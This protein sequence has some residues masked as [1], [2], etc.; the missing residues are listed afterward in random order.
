MNTNNG[1]DL[2]RD[3]LAERVKVFLRTGLCLAA[4]APSVSL[5]RLEAFA[6]IERILGCIRATV[7]KGKRRRRAC[8]EAPIQESD[9]RQLRQQPEPGDPPPPGCQRSTDKPCQHYFL[10]RCNLPY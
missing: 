7:R 2:H 10:H 3:L 9:A 6:I 4:P 1:S 5:A 8:G